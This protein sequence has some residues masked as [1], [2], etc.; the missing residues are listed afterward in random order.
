M[1]LFRRTRP[2]AAPPVATGSLTVRVVED[3]ETFEGHDGSKWWSSGYAPVYE[4]RDGEQHF[5]RLGEHASDGR[6]LYCKVAGSHFYADALQ[7]PRFKTGSPALLRPE[8]DNPYDP[9]AVGVWDGSGSVQVGHIPADLS[10]EV[11]SR[12]ESGEQLVGFVL[13][14]IREHSKS[15]PRTA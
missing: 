5:R 15:G 4:D 8:P 3:T 11:A 1:S 9:N 12:I 6:A 14:E 7:D 13:R 2:K 10:A